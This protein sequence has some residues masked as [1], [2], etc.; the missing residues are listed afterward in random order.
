MHL[1][2]A[3]RPMGSGALGLGLKGEGLVHTV[4]LLPACLLG[5]GTGGNYLTSKCP[6]VGLSKFETKPGSTEGDTVS[7]TFEPCLLPFFFLFSP[8]CYLSC[9]QTT[10]ALQTERL[11]QT[12][13]T[14]SD[15]TVV[16]VGLCQWSWA[17]FQVWVSDHLKVKTATWVRPGLEIYKVRRSR[18]E[19]LCGL[20]QRPLCLWMCP[21]VHGMNKAI[22]LYSSHVFWQRE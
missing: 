13:L 20:T 3:H 9:L 15:L 1:F 22:N 21:D 5:G 17:T 16:G 10:S 7:L 19:C 8:F 12:S 14:S 4:M 6:G 18:E 2:V 11:A